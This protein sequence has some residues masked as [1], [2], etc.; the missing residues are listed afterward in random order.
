M[1]IA[2]SYRSR[3][4]IPGVANLLLMGQADFNAYMYTYMCIY[5]HTCI[6]YVII[7]GVSLYGALLFP[8]A[9]MASL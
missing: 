1:C 3:N 4:Y 7:N 8:Q 9:A 2:N 6:A 5:I